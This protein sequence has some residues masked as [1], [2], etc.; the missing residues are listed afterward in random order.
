MKQIYHSY[1]VLFAVLLIS[2]G[3][4]AQDKRDYAW[5][6]GAGIGSTNYY[7]DVSPYRIHHLKDVYRVYRFLEFNRHYVNRPS[8][9]LL[10]HKQLNSTFGILLQANALQFSMSD[11]YRRANGDLKSDAPNFARSLNFQTDLY[12]IGFDITISSNNGRVFKE[13]ARFYPSVHLGVGLSTFGVK[14]DLYDQNGTRYDYT[15]PGH[16]NDDNFETDLRELNTEEGKRYSNVTPYLNAGVALNFRLSQKFRLA[17]QSDIKY[18][19][20]DYLDDVSKTYKANYATPALAYAAR[21]GYNVV[22][23][24]TLQRGDN[25]GVNDIY[26]NNRLVILYSFGKKKRKDD[27]KAPV[28]YSIKR[29]DFRRP[30]SIRATRQDTMPSA[31]RRQ[32]FI[33]ARNR[34]L[35]D[36]IRKVDSIN[37]TVRLADSLKQL[38][39]RDTSLRQLIDARLDSIQGDLR[40]IKTVIRNQ[41]LMQ[42]YQYLRFQHDSV[43]RL[44]ERLLLRRNLTASDRLQQRVYELQ[45]DSLKNEMRTLIWMSQY[46]ANDLDS[47][48]LEWRPSNS[49]PTGYSPPF[50]FND[51]TIVTQREAILNRHQQQADSIE[52]QYRKRLERL[53]TRLDSLQAQETRS[54]NSDNSQSSTKRDSAISDDEAEV[55]REA[56]EEVEPTETDNSE[57]DS[58]QTIVSN[59]SS[60]IESMQQRLKAARDSAAFYR[61]TLYARDISDTDTIVEKRRWYEKVLP[62]SKRGRQQEELT[63]EARMLKRQEAYYEDQTRTMNR[64]IDRLQRAN[65][66]LENDFDRLRRRRNDRVVTSA[67][68]VVVPAPVNNTDRAEINELREEIALLR[69]QMLKPDTSSDRTPVV[70]PVVAPL[71][72]AGKD[73]VQMASLR[74]D[75]IA[76]QKELDSI[77]RTPAPVV[78]A[79]QP[80]YDVSSFPVISVYFGMNAATLPSTQTDKIAPMTAVAKQNKDAR[81]VL[82]GFADAVGNATVNKAIAIKRI[83]YVRNLLITQFGLSPA[84]IIIEDPEI[85]VVSG[86]RRANPLDRR[87]DLQF[88]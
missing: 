39:N 16:I 64:D 22:N 2:A 51:T 18:S 11:R 48:L 75:L 59:N 38:T 1:R 85:P 10:A 5:E 78:K 61:R 67:P 60:A 66:L 33:S 4:Q 41:S 12:D 50:R 29:F 52:N 15:F 86:A 88:K 36:S 28:V 19:G 49:N 44:S 57:L 42:G 80:L 74:A 6:I 43:A 65:R 81:I 76:L 58:L 77:R 54:A 46:P 21:P 27:F 37:K 73:S 26:I 72:Q 87:V 62:R 3:L 82:K 35:A 45:K 25:N 63:D 17:L 23:P 70:A 56:L 13:D 83:N 32:N 71:Q 8:F 55:L 31:I 84:Q 53:Q 79:A 14:G 7:G 47:T 40:D 34:Y 68:A 30:D 69:T 9:S 20:S 24:A